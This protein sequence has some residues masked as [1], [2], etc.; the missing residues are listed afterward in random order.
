MSQMLSTPSL[1]ALFVKTFLLKIKKLFHWKKSQIESKRLF[2]NLSHIILLQTLTD[3]QTPNF[4]S[5]LKMTLLLLH[6][7]L[8][9]LRLISIPPLNFTQELNT[10]DIEINHIKKWVEENVGVIIPILNILNLSSF[11]VINPLIRLTF[12]FLKFIF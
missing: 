3:I 9:I 6:L 10:P 8:H 4:A 5:T 11:F 2:L 12:Q 7:N 1:K